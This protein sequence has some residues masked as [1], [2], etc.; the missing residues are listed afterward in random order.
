MIPTRWRRLW[1]GRAAPRPAARPP[2]RSC[3]SAARRGRGD[4][5]RSCPWRRPP[6]PSATAWWRRFVPRVATGW[7]RAQR[8]LR[9]V[10]RRLGEVRAARERLDAALG[11]LEESVTSGKQF[12]A[13]AARAGEV[14]ADADAKAGARDAF[15]EARVARKLAQ[16]EV[17]ALEA[18]RRRGEGPRRQHPRAPAR[19]PRTAGPRR[20]HG[21]RRA[22]VRRGAG[23]GAHRVRALARGVQ[24]GLG[25][26]RDDA[27]DGCRGTCPGSVRPSTPSAL[28]CGCITRA[29]TPACRPRR[30]SRIRATLP[31]RL[32][33]PA[34]PVHRLAA[35][36]AG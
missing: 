10:E 4:A 30:G 6:S 11:V 9:D 29:S 13:L 5:A 7:R 27:V 19:V 31:G 14:L 12:A 21:R 24:P 36:S 2:R 15:A 26:L 3:G 16:S 8:E 18:E 23:R 17:D 32:D 20:R 22:A 28:R 33:L 1:R 25:W 34:D 35:G